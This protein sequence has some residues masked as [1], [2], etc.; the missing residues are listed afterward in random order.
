MRHKRLFLVALI[1]LGVGVGILVISEQEAA[2]MRVE[3]IQTMKVADDKLMISC[4]VSNHTGRAGYLLAYPQI[5]SGDRWVL[6][7]AAGKP[8]GTHNGL[9]ADGISQF[10]VHVSDRPGPRCL[11]IRYDIGKSPRRE[12][13]DQL[14]KKIHLGP[15]PVRQELREFITPPFEL[16]AR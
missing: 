14:L 10:F 2:P 8:I 5:L 16:P 15:L 11:Q 6:D 1:L 9:S 7:D 13:I 4:L 12:K 3:I